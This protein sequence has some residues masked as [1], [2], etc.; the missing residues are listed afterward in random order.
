MSSSIK[1]TIVTATIGRPQLARC[2]E[3]VKNQTHKNIEHIVVADGQEAERK[4]YDLIDNEEYTILEEGGILNYVR[5]PFPTGIN[6]YNGHLIYGAMTFIARGDYIIYLD[7]DNTL[8]PTHVEDCLRAITAYSDKVNRWSFS[9]RN[10]VDQNGNFLCQD[11]CE[12]LGLF[13]SVI[14]DRDYFLDVNTYFL[15]KAIAVA[16]SPVWFCKFREPGQPEIDRKIM[17]I[18]RQHFPNYDSTYKYTVN[19]AVGGSGLSVTPEFF[20]AGNAEML[21]RYNGNLPWHRK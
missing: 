20:T 16:I 14:D 7:D 4:I 10:I 1:I 11:N 17:A 18:L 6:R 5:L 12:S 15:P 9:F 13:P 3:S 19:Y 2:V 8:E 21:R